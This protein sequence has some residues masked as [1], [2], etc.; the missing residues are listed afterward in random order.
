MRTF[1][2]DVRY[3]L[4]LM[5]RSPLFTAV[6][7][8]VLALGIG[9]NTAIF[10][11]VNSIVLRPLPL[12]DSDRLAFV[13]ETSVGQGW[14]RVGPSGPNYVD[15]K[16]QSTSFDDLAALE[17]GSGT[18]TGSGEPHQIP[19][20]RVSTN[21]LSVLGAAPLI[22]RDFT[23]TEGWEDRVIIISY[24]FW[25]QNLGLNP[26]AIG[27]RLMVDDLPYTIIGVLPRTFWSPVPSELL[28]PWSTADL[29]A[30]GRTDHNFG[31]IGRL[32]RGVSAERAN[33]EMTSIEQRI[34]EHVLPLKGW[35][36][37]VVPLH[38]LV[39]EEM[40]ASRVVLLAAVGFVLLIA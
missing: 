15:F 23:S 4:R 20:I 25:E 11:V 10:S 33:A 12:H 14:S 2:D 34:G 28:V 29:R 3:G 35:G 9:A 7:V 26:A 17:L 8:G 38:R 40:G 39:G 13:W 6:T 32:R 18:V 36:T 30:K 37:T 24:G 31:V 27:S 5:A 22:G 16:E 19:A 21:Y 1:A